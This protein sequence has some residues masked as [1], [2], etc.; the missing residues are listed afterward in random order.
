MEMTQE[1]KPKTDAS[2]PVVEWLCCRNCL[3][4]CFWYIPNDDCCVMY[5]QGFIDHVEVE[6]KH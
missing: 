6:C 3:Q 4:L 1:L 2:V 5:K